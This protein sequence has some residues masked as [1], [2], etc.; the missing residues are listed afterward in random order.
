[1]AE[2]NN[3][4]QGGFG[5]GQVKAEPKPETKAEKPGE[6]KAEKPKEDK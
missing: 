3:E 1:M 2:T 4:Q 5:G 6:D